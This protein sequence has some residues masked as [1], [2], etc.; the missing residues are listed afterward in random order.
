MA[1]AHELKKD[2]WKRV[3]SSPFFMVG[4]S[5]HGGEP[6]TAQLDKDQVDTL[7]FFIGKTNRLA[8]G[9]AA[10]AQFVSK[11]HDLFA[12][13]SGKVT[14]D[15]N[16]G[17]IDKLWSKQAEAWFPDGKTDANLAL[18]RFDIADAEIWETDLS[19]GGKLKMIFGGTIKADEAGSHTK[20]GSTA[21]G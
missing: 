1:D 7:W 16:P 4:L 20:V 17:M 11:G 3:E 14:V 9:G 21:G 2:F 18:L 10:L 12:T 6:L 8:G 5:G 13:L 15:N 19:L